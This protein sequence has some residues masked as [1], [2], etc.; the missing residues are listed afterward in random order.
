[1]NEVNGSYFPGGRVNFIAKGR[2]QA[3][4]AGKQGQG[5]ALGSQAP[6]QCGADSTGGADNDRPFGRLGGSDA[7]CLV[8]FWLGR[9]FSAV[10]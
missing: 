10:E 9:V 1:M 4:A 6:G 8:T 3:G 5:I 2:Q 7:N